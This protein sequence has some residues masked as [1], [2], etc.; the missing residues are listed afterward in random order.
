M[1]L[2]THH[3]LA[4]RSWKNRAT[5]L[6]PLGYNR[7]CNKVTL[8]LPFTLVGVANGIENLAATENGRTRC[9]D[10]AISARTRLR[11]EDL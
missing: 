9:E 5:T 2:T 7:A 4:P 1:L 3:F 6:P 8:L 11:F 10:K